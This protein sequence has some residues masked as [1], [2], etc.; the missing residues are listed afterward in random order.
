MGPCT[1]RRLP[2]TSA[3]PVRCS[4]IGRESSRDERA[5]NIFLRPRDNANAIFFLF[6]FVVPFDRTARSFTLWSRSYYCVWYV[7]R[8]IIRY[9]FARKLVIFMDFRPV[10]NKFRL[11]RHRHKRPGRAA[12]A[13][14]NNSPARHFD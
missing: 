13:R 6:S 5:P 9:G 12:T 2:G 14:F 10:Q 1:L 7:S 8:R 4:D 3:L 11:C